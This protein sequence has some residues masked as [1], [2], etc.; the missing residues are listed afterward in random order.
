MT[1]LVGKGK[2]FHS[3]LDKAATL[4]KRK[5]G[6]GAEFMKE[7]MS[8]PGIKQTEIQERGLGDVMGAPK[9]THEQF[10]AMLGS[11]PAPAIHEKVLGKISD[12]EFFQKANEIAKDYYG[13]P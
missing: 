8:L 7:L 10:M 5:V 11:K 12:S 13:V 9:M 1:E 2:P 6:T 3:G 4:L